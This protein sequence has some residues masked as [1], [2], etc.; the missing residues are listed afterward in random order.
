[1]TLRTL[2]FSLVLAVLPGIGS[3]ATHQN[4][5]LALSARATASESLLPDM[6]PEKANDGDIKTRWSGI[7]GHNSGVWFE[8]RWPTS[9]KVAE[10]VVRQYDRYSE[11]WDLETWNSEKNEWVVQGHFG[12]KGKR[13]S[14]VVIAKFKPVKTDAVRI[15]N[16][17]N[18]PSFNEVEV[19]SDINTYPPKLAVASDLQGN[20][21]GVL[22]DAF[23]SAPIART[24]VTFSGRTLTGPW[25]ESTESDDT[26]LFSIPMRIDEQGLVHAVAANGAST[27]LDPLAFQFGL[28]PLSADQKRVD[29][30]GQWRFMTDPPEGFWKPDFDD[31]SWSTIQVPSN[32]E[33]KGFRSL[34]GIGGYRRL[35]QTPTGTG[36]LKLRFDGVY[37]G[38]EIWVN[39]RRLAYHEGGFTPFEVDV[40]EAVHQRQNILAV[41]V[42]EHT[43]VSDK[44]DHMSLYADFPLTGISRKVYLFRVPET[45]IA[46]YTVHT[47]F[48]PG[49]DVAWMDAEVF[50]I[51][52]KL[53]PQSTNY[54]MEG[55]LRKPNGSIVA[56]THDPVE[57]RFLPNGNGRCSAHF[58]LRIDHPR[59]W[60]A[61]NPNL[62]ILSLNLLHGKSLIQR[63]EQRVGL[64]Q[65]SVEGA[66]LLINGTAVKIRGTCHHDSDPLDG[67]AVTVDRTRQD[68][69][70]IKE[71]NLNA[72]RTSHYPPIPE[73][74][75][76][77]DEMGIY[78]EDEASFCWADATEDLLKAPRVIQM[79]AEMIA[80]DRNHPS[81]FMWSICNESSFGVD[82]ELSHNWV[83]QNEPSRP[84]AAATSEWLEIATLHNPI[85]IKRIT[86][87]EGLDRPLLFD[88]SWGI[89]QGIFN[90]VA[91]MWV[92]PGMRDYYVV[93]LQAIYR[94]MMDSKATQ[95]S[96]IWAW[97]DDL[98]CVPGRG[99]E[100]GRGMTMSHFI[101]NQYEIP[102]RG[103]VGDAPWGVVD[104]WRR[105]KPEFWITKKL[106]SPVKVAEGAMTAPSTGEPIRVEVENQYDFTNLSELRVTYAVG[107]EKG[108]AKVSV[109]P[110]SKGTL[111]V[112]PVNRIIA[113]DVLDLKF[114]NS[115]GMLVDEYRLP[116]GK[117]KASKQTTQPAVLP[118]LKTRAIVTLA[119]NGLEID[120]RDFELQFDTD[121]GYLRKCVAHGIPTLLEL[122][123][124]HVLP[125]ESPQQPIP[126]RATWSSKSF[127]WVRER[128]DVL[129]T[130]TGSYPGFDGSYHISISPDGGMTVHSSF[131]YTGPERRAREI[132]LAFSVPRQCDTVS[133]VRNA[134]WSVYP[135]DH[136]GRPVG[137]ASALAKHPDTVP[138][139]WSWSLD[140]SPMGTND[141]RSTKRNIQQG[142]ISYPSGI[143]VSIE[144]DGT[145]SLR[146]MVDTDRIDVNLSDWFG[147]SNV[148]WRE[149]TTN[150]GTGR[151]IRSG[152]LLTSTARLQL[153]RIIGTL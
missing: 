141:F 29:L 123:S 89:F 71:A 72:V 55:S 20:Y 92:D 148:G 49:H 59:T 93:P 88:E 62:Y 81:V 10:V 116:I 91:E 34:D 39:G 26:G 68:L 152:D 19:Y 17:T 21:I 57:L 137:S 75:D 1:M 64:R 23:G 133:W 99:L 124:L 36:R 16:I 104:G 103:I 98:F 27:T 73:L 74:L 94:T 40:T 32:W 114:E 2:F 76:M 125:T 42:A 130:I 52:E 134:E 31:A 101:D 18:G 25:S 138:P 143:G 78:V 15:A 53:E 14:L 6:T 3:T 109:A 48:E 117:L 82:F 107:K 69:R 43:V 97:S 111:T 58:R 56:K 24:K 121:G 136:I 139:T 127:K 83:R 50:G 63:L 80:R 147:G 65:T 129:V 66:H 122:P 90:D 113:G 47:E 106:H 38:A 12:E 145:Q 128:E 8:L 70:L 4:T 28:T 84:T 41:R 110:H 142:S 87:N 105:Q 151:V 54:R 95:G 112:V 22:T 11:E 35:F 96:Q 85:S 140:N 120:G 61:E 144:S 45:H 108:L 7:P 146:A 149:W 44:F 126:Y 102:G 150:Y 9:V 115:S 37:S 100:Y 79:T 132:G 118:S 13:L 51:N 131:T 135:D 33:M 86:D 153:V 67:R 77:A 30:D 46:R 60:T 119:G 5:N